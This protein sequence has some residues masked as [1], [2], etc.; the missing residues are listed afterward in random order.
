MDT[1]AWTAV[2]M[3]A[4]AA[5]VAVAPTSEVVSPAELLIIKPFRKRF[6]KS[7]GARLRPAVCCLLQSP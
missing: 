3:S 4:L 7:A 5:E 1:D 6:I 2:E